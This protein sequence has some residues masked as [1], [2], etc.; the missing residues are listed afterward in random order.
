[1]S[2]PW[3]RSDQCDYLQI[4]MM[5]VNVQRRSRSRALIG[6]WAAEFILLTATAMSSAAPLTCEQYNTLS[7]AAALNLERELAIANRPVHNAS[8]EAVEGQRRLDDYMGQFADDALIHGLQG[9]PEPAE[10]AQTRTHYAPILMG[11]SEAADP[12]GR[13]TETI[14]VVAGPMGAHRYKAQIHIPGLP[15]DFAYF[16]ERRPLRIRGQTVFDYGYFEPASG[17]YLIRERWSNH[18]NAFRTGQLWRYMLE[19]PERPANWPFD[20]RSDLSSTDGAPGGKID[21]Q[22]ARLNAVFNGE[23]AL[24]HGEFGLSESGAFV[25][26][27]APDGRRTD[28]VSELDGYAFIA[29]FMHALAQPDWVSRFRQWVSISRDPQSP[30]QATLYGADCEAAEAASRPALI[31]AG[32]FKSRVEPLLFVLQQSR[33]FGMALPSS[34]LVGAPDQDYHRWPISAWGWIAFTLYLP[35]SESVGR[36][37]DAVMRL[38]YDGS[39]LT[40]IN[41]A[42]FRRYLCAQSVHSP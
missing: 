18:D 1:M 32:E 17:R 33:L 37:V 23:Y 16:D 41:S 40:R 24:K 6:R 30:L 27:D 36:C 29:D 3:R 13:L 42:W 25:V 34:A 7:A 10:K 8:P 19:R 5:R 31:A 15:V 11:D 38:G 28:I 35:E 14:R 20:V 22:G 12:E 39:G 9:Q 2:A 21:L 26:D 4:R